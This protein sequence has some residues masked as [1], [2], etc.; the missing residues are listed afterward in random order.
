MQGD[1]DLQVQILVVEIRMGDDD[2]VLAERQRHARGN[3][4]GHLADQRDRL[5]HSREHAAH[6]KERQRRHGL[7][8]DVVIGQRTLLLDLFEAGFDVAETRRLLVQR[9]LQ[10]GLTQHQHAADLAR[11]H[12]VVHHLGDLLEGE[13]QLLQRQDAVQPRQLAGAVIAVA[14]GG[15]DADRAE[16]ADAVVVAQQAARHP[17][18]L[19]KFPDPEHLSALLAIGDGPQPPA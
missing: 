4:A 3:R 8:D 1:A 9:A 5:I 10:L 17:G 19:R 14:A 7:Q 16:Q 18:D 12:L 6:G 11:L 15:I 2:N 13:T